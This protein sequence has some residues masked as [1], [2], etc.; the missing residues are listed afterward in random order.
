MRTFVIV[1]VLELAT[2]DRWQGLHTRCVVPT[3]DLLCT[4]KYVRNANIITSQTR[5]NVSIDGFDVHHCFN[6]SVPRE[7]FIER[8]GPITTRGNFSWLS[9]KHDRLFDLSQH[10]H[11]MYARK[12]F[13]GIVD[14][15]DV[16]IRSP[17]LMVHHVYMVHGHSGCLFTTDGSSQAAGGEEDQDH[18]YMS[19]SLPNG[20][21]FEITSSLLWYGT[22]N[23]VRPAG[24][25]PLTWWSYAAIEVASKRTETLMSSH[26]TYNPG[27]F[28]GGTIEVPRLVET[29][30]WNV[31]RM[32]A[33]G[34]LL[35]ASLTVHSFGVQD[36][37]LFAHALDVLPKPSLP[38]VPVVTAATKFISNRELRRRLFFMR[39]ICHGK[40]AVEEVGG[41]VYDRSPS[42][43]CVGWTFNEGDVFSMVMLAGPR[44][45]LYVRDLINS[46]TPLYSNTTRL[47]HV[48]W[49]MLYVADIGLSLQTQ[50]TYSQQVDAVCLTATRLDAVRARLNGGLPALPM[51]VFEQFHLLSKIWTDGATWPMYIPQSSP[52]AFPHMSPELVFLLFYVSPMLS[53]SLLAWNKCISAAIY[54]TITLATPF[55]LRTCR[56]AGTLEV[57]VANTLRLASLLTFLLLYCT[58]ARNPLRALCAVVSF[59]ITIHFVILC[60]LSRPAN[61]TAEYSIKE[62]HY[63]SSLI[64]GTVFGLLTCICTTCLVL[65]QI[66]VCKRNQKGIPAASEKHPIILTD[67]RLAGREALI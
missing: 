45:G 5:Q 62:P 13:L 23:D 66:G 61:T 25:W 37:F 58:Q 33:S 59:T 6:A 56:T 2:A 53:W 46:G 19:A 52:C 14:S 1:C 12:F 10:S 67:A 38:W 54:I 57:L 50:Q 34:I 36:S 22:F 4:S 60:L 63:Q 20:V 7:Y 8:I 26:Y 17:P 32:P 30:V 16:A 64:G 21:S 35:F 65:T 42:S 44:K 39:P 24:A 18:C 9:M 49:N 11:P 27:Q 28:F 48:N 43:S 40:T 15:G 47:T 31:G 41:V 55:V 29:F 51:D 3:A